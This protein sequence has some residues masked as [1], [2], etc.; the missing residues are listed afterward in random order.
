[1]MV[2]NA[3]PSPSSVA[4]SGV[5]ARDVAGDVSQEVEPARLSRVVTWCAARAVNADPAGP[6]AGCRRYVAGPGRL[7]V[8]QALPILGHARRRAVAE[9]VR[10]ERCQHE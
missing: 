5:D 7:Q 1:M 10:D 2:M 6:H 8:V 4:A 3:K 9:G